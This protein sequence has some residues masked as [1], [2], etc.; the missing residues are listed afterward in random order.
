MTCASCVIRTAWKSALKKVPGVQDATVNLAT[1]SA[2]RDFAPGPTVAA[3]PPPVRDAGYEP[4]APK[5]HDAD[6]GPWAGFA[7]VASGCCCLPAGAADAGRLL[8]GRT[9]CCRPGC[10]FPAG[11]AGQFILGARFYKAGW[12]ALRAPGPA[13]WTCWWPLAPSAGWGL[14][15]YWLLG[16]HAEMVP[17]LYFGRPRR[18]W[19][20]W[21]A[22]QVAGARAKRQTTAA[23]NALRRTCDGAGRDPAGPAVGAEVPLAEVLG[24]TGWWCAR[25]SASRWT[26]RAGGGT[27]AGG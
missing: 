16:W 1:E 24:A 8:F 18:W 4:R 6:P 22:G 19:S 3:R 13:T 7:P 15:M 27:D 5:A 23:I 12:H 2:H 26:A 9:G 17:H 14:S 25:A 20:R 21:S 11:H 10:S